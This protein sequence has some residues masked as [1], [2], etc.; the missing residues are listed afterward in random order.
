[1]EVGEKD[2]G[3]KM[4]GALRSRAE[5]WANSEQLYVVNAPHLGMSEW[6]EGLPLLPTLYRYRA[7]GSLHRASR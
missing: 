3:N 1:M 4:I 7:M 2:F 5:R 6:E